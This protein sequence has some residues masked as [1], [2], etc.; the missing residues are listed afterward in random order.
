[1]LF[2]QKIAAQIFQKE[3]KKKCE[4]ENNIVLGKF[5]EVLVYFRLVIVFCWSSDWIFSI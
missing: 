1:M 2:A 5:L 3:L 4:T